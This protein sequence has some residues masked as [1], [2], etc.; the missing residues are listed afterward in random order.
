MIKFTHTADIHFGMENYGKIDP[1]TGIHSRLLDFN[2]ALSFCVNYSIEQ[3][4]DF[5]LFCGDAYKT[6]NP[7]PTQQ[8]LLFSALIKLYKAN[9]PVIIIVGNHD[10][11]ASFGKVHSLDLFSN[12][13]IDGFHVISKPKILNLTTKNGPVQIVGIPWPTRNNLSISEKHTTKSYSDITD[14][15]SST[16]SEIIASFAN[17]LNPQIPA[18]LA[19]HLTVSSGLFSGSEKRAIFGSDPTFLPSQLAI[20]PFDYV[21]LGHLHRYQNLNPNGYPAIIYPGSI[22]RI[23]FG[24]RKE[25]KGFCLVTINNTPDINLENKTNF[26]FIKT[27]TRNLIQIEVKLQANKDQTTQILEELDKHDL[28]GAIIKILYHVPEN[29]KD[30]IDLQIIQKKCEPAMH[31]VGI[32]PIRENQV[33]ERRSDLKISMDFETLIGAYLDT[34]PDL[35]NRKQELVDKALVLFE[36]SKIN[37]IEE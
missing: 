24:E 9:I 34:K 26:E 30:K 10:N 13:P 22:E 35:K 5:F 3:N 23:D 16:V 27:P 18:I 36:E 21:A 11:P 12:L 15:I 32:I 19:G 6:T 37:Q 25:Q 2:N 33:R 20:K 17:Q 1:E 8:K 31:L 28:N 29:E 4:V 7:T 14:Y